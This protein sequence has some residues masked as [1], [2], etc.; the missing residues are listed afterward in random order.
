MLLIRGVTLE[1]I[2]NHSIRFRS[3][4]LDISITG[5]GSYGVEKIFRP[6]VVHQKHP[7]TKPPQWSRSEF[8][9]SGVTLADTIGETGTHSM[10]GEIG[11]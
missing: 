11:V 7:L 10:N 4:E 8:I 6:A 3:S 5:M 1:E 2:A 9:P